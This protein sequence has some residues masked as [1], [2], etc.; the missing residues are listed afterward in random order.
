M[1][2]RQSVS[3]E[4]NYLKNQIWLWKEREREIGQKLLPLRIYANSIGT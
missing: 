1:E 3:G 2:C 4:V